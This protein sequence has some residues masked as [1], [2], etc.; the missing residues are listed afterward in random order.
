MT[1]A[2]P[3]S[4]R[5]KAW[6]MQ[7]APDA[8]AIQQLASAIRIPFPL[9]QILM[10]RGVSDAAS[11]QAFLYPEFKKLHLPELLPHMRE[12]AER[13][14]R[15]I[16]Q[17]EQIVLFGDYDV[18]GITGTSML[19]HIITAA[20][21]KVKTYIPHRVS[22]GYGL[23]VKAIEELAD[24]GA[25]LIVSI[26]CGGTACEPVAAARARHVD[27]IITDH[28]EL[29]DVLPDAT[30]FVHPRLSGSHYPN[31]HLCGAGVA[32]KLAWA[33]A[34][35]LCN[36]EKI[37]T[38]YK[39]LL[40]EFAALVGLGTIADVVPLVGE[41]RILA[42]FGLAQLPRCGL[43]GIQALIAA[44]GYG[45]REIDGT[46]V[47]F[48]LAPR[49]NA[50]GRM[51]HADMAVEL[52]TSADQSKAQE[53]AEYLEKQ[54]R[55][56]Q[57]T[58][59]KMVEAAQKQIESQ[60]AHE[61]DLPLVLVVHSEA[62]HAG[63]VGIVASRLVDKYNRPAFVL[64]C[65]ENECH[66][67]A[68]SIPNFSIHQ[69]IEH[70]RH[71]LISGGGHAMAGGVKFERRHLDA[72]REGLNEYAANVLSPDDLIPRLEID[73]EIKLGEVHSEFARLLAKLEPHGRGNPKPKFL[74][75]GVKIS[76][77]PK[78]V[79]STGSHLQMLIRQDNVTARAIA[80]KAGDAEP[81]LP[82]G[83]D[84]DLVAEIK[85]NEYQGVQRAEIYVCD[86]ARCDGTPMETDES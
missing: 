67:S 41:N 36:G 51:D 66:G 44:A 26:D 18:D 74:I 38:Q 69:A 20:G 24:A 3:I 9:A 10:T 85:L 53:I 62:H 47:G 45:D 29:N 43:T 75:S 21:G 39:N 82:V 40:I 5:K 72:F 7:P 48:G 32:Y 35:Q 57:V 54:N 23:S 19:W 30:V 13:L 42:R 59:R 79:G 83:A 6:V 16:R 27:I 11:A 73:A 71:L 31:E 22:E 84:V 64:A 46:V 60:L 12:A 49:L 14:T 34:Q 28:H 81:Y 8:A 78:R 76:A 25:Q 15:A 77:P 80:F 4:F 37:H 17:Q 58:E 33:T 50:A 1:V 52:L 70:V 56:R 2:E 65:D 68:R 61:G 86:I 55:D 63:V